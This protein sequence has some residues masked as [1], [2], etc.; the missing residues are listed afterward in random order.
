MNS[1][2]VIQ[3]FR[4][5]LLPCLDCTSNRLRGCRFFVLSIQRLREPRRGQICLLRVRKRGGASRRHRMAQSATVYRPARLLGVDLSLVAC[6]MN[7]GRQRWRH[8]ARMEFLWTTQ[9]SAGVAGW[10]GRELFGL[11][12]FVMP[13]AQLL[14]TAPA[15]VT[16]ISTL[17]AGLRIAWGKLA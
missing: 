3:A 1:R 15:I 16:L 12:S 9:V 14:N 8:D 10:N 2:D 17:P 13:C 11:S 5:G 4:F 6:T 7:T